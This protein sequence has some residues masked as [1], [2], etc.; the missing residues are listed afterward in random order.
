MSLEL[1]Q[2]FIEEF[3]DFK[4]QIERLIL[5]SSEFNTLLGEYREIDEE[6]MKVEQN[7]S[8]LSDIEAEKLKKR[9]LML[10]DELFAMLK[11]ASA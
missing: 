2:S 7:V 5:S 10:K 8:P 9:R 1:H 6:V 3:S 4:E 11:A